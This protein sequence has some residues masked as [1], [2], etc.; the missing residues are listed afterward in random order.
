MNGIVPCTPDDL[1]KLPGIGPYTA[2]AVAC[3]AC[4]FPSVF[5]ETNIRSVMLHFFFPEKEAVTDREIMPIIKK[6]MDTGNPKEWYWALMDYGA[7]LKKLSPNPG[8]RSARYNR[9]SSFSGSFRQIRGSLIRVLVSGEAPAVEELLERVKIDLGAELNV[10]V[11]EEDFYRAL[12][13][14]CKESMV[15]EE[16]GKYR[17]SG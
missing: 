2:G 8:R 15:A 3:F 10:H 12:E 13:T 6:T 7:A 11:K 16:G 17:I 9:Q 5:I 4:N 1:A 14:L